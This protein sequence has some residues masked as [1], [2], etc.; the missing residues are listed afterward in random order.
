MSPNRVWLS[1][2]IAVYVAETHWR[3]WRAEDCDAN[4]ALWRC[5]SATR[6]MLYHF[7][8]REMG[9]SHLMMSDAIS[10]PRQRCNGRYL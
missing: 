6:I 9:V 4:N 1:K 7:S 10:L 2:Y 5:P 3:C 8:C